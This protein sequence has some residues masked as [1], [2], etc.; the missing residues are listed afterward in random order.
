MK[1]LKP[2]LLN[3][4][5][6]N[7]AEDD[8]PDWSADITYS[9]GDEV[10]KNHKIWVSNVNE[11]SEEENI[12][13]DPE[14][15]DQSLV[16]ARWLYKSPT[17]QYALLDDLLH[18]QTQTTGET[19]IVDIEVT[20]SFNTI[21]LFAVDSS[22]TTV[23]IVHG[24]ATTK[25]AEIYS[26]AVPVDNWYDWVNTTFFPKTERHVIEGAI[27]YSGSIVRITVAGATPKIGNVVIGN[28]IVVGET[29]QEQ[30]RLKKQTYTDITRS[31]FGDGVVVTKRATARDITYGVKAKAEG[32]DAIF[33]ALD[34]LDGVPVVTFVNSELRLLISFGYITHT[35][36]PFDAQNDFTFKIINRGIT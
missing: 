35:D 16:E 20:E 12:N 22:V 30:T 10:I 7:I 33:Q 29:N 14:L 18:T 5:A 24:G 17:N 26:G 13:I 19:I 21:A 28:A 31:A 36:I 4:D 32:F 27:G 3:L 6:S 2:A 34:A 25:V 23:E 1:I 8:A 15:E 11:Y 9:Y